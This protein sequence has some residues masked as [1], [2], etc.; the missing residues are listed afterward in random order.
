MR[1]GL[2]HGSVSPTAGAQPP[3]AGA[4]AARS[5]GAAGP[6]GRGGPRAHVGRP[7]ARPCRMGGLVLVRAVWDVALAAGQ[8]AVTN[9]AQGLPY[10]GMPYEACDISGCW[11]RKSLLH[12]RGLSK[13]ASPRRRR[14]SFPRRRSRRTLVESVRWRRRW[15]GAV[16]ASCIERVLCAI[17]I[18]SWNM[19]CDFGGCIPGA[20]FGEPNRNTLRGYV[21]EQ[22]L[23]A[24]R[25]GA[26]CLMTP[27]FCR[28]SMPTCGL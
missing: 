6:G 10:Q 20:G 8:G 19:S 27:C 9:R 16:F 24:Y 18:V 4:S 5:Q 25:N 23:C 3:P 11:R 15:S 17:V 1:D 12:L 28:P 21:H 7:G 26:A 2:R 14:S 22:R 13:G